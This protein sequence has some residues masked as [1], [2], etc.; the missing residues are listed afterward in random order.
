MIFITNINKAKNSSAVIVYPID[1]LSQAKYLIRVME[2]PTRNLVMKPEPVKKVFT[3]KD[4]L[5]LGLK[6]IR[7]DKSASLIMTAVIG[8]SA[9]LTEL[10]YANSILFRVLKESYGTPVGSEVQ[11]SIV[12]GAFLFMITIIVAASY[13]KVKEGERDYQVLIISGASSNQILKFCLLEN[14]IIG[15]A[16]SISGAFGSLLIF[17]LIYGS[18]FGWPL[19]L[20]SPTFDY[21]ISGV[22]TAVTSISVSI[23]SPILFSNISLNKQKTEIR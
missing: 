6:G 19:W 3:S 4:D 14:V 15:L 16:G 7:G 1:S 20:L 11:D 22:I 21:F 18:Q 13:L 12:V 9:A 17:M 2:N 8:L 23:L 10:T 5:A